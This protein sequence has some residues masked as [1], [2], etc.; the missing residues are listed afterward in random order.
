M[1]RVSLDEAVPG[2]GAASK[3]C[4]RRTSS[5][6]STSRPSRD[7]MRASSA[8][9]TLAVSPL[10]ADAPEVGAPLAR[11]ARRTERRARVTPVLVG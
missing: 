6:R 3:I 5:S 9:M 1:C 11:R 10:R 4:T 8:W 7:A 2:G